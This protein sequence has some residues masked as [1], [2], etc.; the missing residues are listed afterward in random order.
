MIYIFVGNE[1]TELPTNFTYFEGG[2]DEVGL[3]NH[4]LEDPLCSG[5]QNIV[6]FNFTVDNALRFSYLKCDCAPPNVYIIFKD[7]KD[8]GEFLSRL[9]EHRRKYAKRVVN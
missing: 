3:Q 2:F 7:E 8:I 4:A 1:S 5:S 9:P 6:F